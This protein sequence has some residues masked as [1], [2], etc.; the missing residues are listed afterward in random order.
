M[1]KEKKKIV[2]VAITRFLEVADVINDCVSIDRGF[3]LLSRIVVIVSEREIFTKR[4]ATNTG[5][6]GE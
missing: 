5:K 6:L 1:K 4:I 2:V 3:G